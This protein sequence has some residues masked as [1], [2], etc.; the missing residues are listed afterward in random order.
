MSF[1]IGGS[2]QG[3]FVKPNAQTNRL[4]QQI[5]SG[6]R[7]NSAA[8]D[9][10]GLAISTAM[11]N[12]LRGDQV[13]VRNT[14]EGISY[15]QTASG[16]LS[17]VTDNLQRLRELAVQSAN[18]SLNSSD[19][20]ALQ[21]EV[22]QLT[23]STRTIL[24]DADFNG[25]VLFSDDKSLN[26]QTG[27]NAGE[28]ISVPVSNLLEQFDNQGFAGLD[29][30]TQQ[31]ASDSLSVI[32]NSLQQVGSRQAELGAVA[33]R[34]G[35]SINRSQSSIENTA[36]ARSRISDADLAKAVSEL[37]LGQIRSQ[38]QT[39]VQAQANVQGKQVLSLL[40]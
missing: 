32:D 3:T 36:A 9:A 26:F 24:R 22:A 25:Q 35:A 13:G 10:A 5:S 8:D 15:V 40:G 23:D 29:V 27:A 18:G 31:S 30:R 33:N 11:S 7:I 16:A 37:T 6:S 34:F 14:L 39:A 19:R 20:D 28:Q 21:Q 38:V 17:Q 4:Y 12:Q 1:P 2:V